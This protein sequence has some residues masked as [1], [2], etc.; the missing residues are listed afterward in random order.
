MSFIFNRLKSGVDNTREAF[1]NELQEQVGDVFSGDNIHVDGFFSE[2]LDQV[3]DSERFD[4][5]LAERAEY[6]V[7]TY[8]LVFPAKAV[9]TSSG[10]LGF[11]KSKL[12]KD[13]GV[14][15]DELTIRREKILK[16]LRDASFHVRLFYS[17]D[18]SKIFAK[19]GATE[20]RF[21]AVAEAHDYLLRL[22]SVSVKKVLEAGD[23]LPNGE[24]RLPV[25]LDYPYKDKELAD[26]LL[27]NFKAF[28]A[29]GE[30]SVNMSTVAKKVHEQS[31]MKP[32]TYLHVKYSSKAEARIINDHGV[33]I[34]K[35]YG[36]SIL[37]TY[38]RIKLT[39]ISIET[40]KVAI[41][42]IKG[43]GLNLDKEQFAGTIS[44]AY[45]V[46][47]SETVAEN[48]ELTVDQLYDKWRATSHKP[49]TQPIDDIREYAGE[50][51]ALYFAFLGFYTLWLIPAALV[52]FVVF[53][54]QLYELNQATGSYNFVTGNTAIRILTN[55][56]DGDEFLVPL[57]PTEVPELPYYAIFIAFWGSFL[58]EFWKRAQNTLSLKWGTS[59]YERM[60]VVRPEF[61]PTFVLP[62]VVTGLP[63]LYRS[64][65]FFGLK[66]AASFGTVLFFVA[67]VIGAIFGTLVF[68]EVV[69]E[70]GLP[71]AIAPQIAL[72]VNAVLIILLGIVFKKVAAFLTDWENHRTDIEYEDSL[73]AKTFLFSFFNS[74]STLMYYAFIKSGTILFPGGR[75]QYCMA[76][77]QELG[78][79]GNFSV[80]ELLDVDSCYGAVG[81]SLFILFGVQIVIS[82]SV[83]VGLP[84]LKS[85]FKIYQTKA[86]DAAKNAQK[87]LEEVGDSLMGPGEEKEAEPLDEEMLRRKLQSPAEQQLFLAPYETP[88]DDYLEIAL[89]FGYVTLFVSAFPLAP[90]F[91]LLAC[92]VEFKV[93]S[94]KICFLS[95]KPD[96]ASAQDIGTWLYIFTILSFISV[97]VNS[98]ILFFT[99]KE[100]ILTTA[101]TDSNI[102]VWGF[103][104]FV[105]GIYS[106]KLI[107]DY[108]ITDIPAAVSIQLR[109]QDHIERKIFDLEPD[110]E[111]SLDLTGK[112][113]KKDIEESAHMDD[114]EY[115]QN[116]TEVDGY[117][118]LIDYMIDHT[119]DAL[120]LQG[121]HGEKLI[122]LSR[123]IFEDAD[124]NKDGE[125]SLKELRTM[126]KS[127]KYGAPLAAMSKFEIKLLMAA[128]DLN[129]DGSISPEEFD[130]FMMGES[131][132]GKGMEL[133][134]EEEEVVVEKEE[135]QEDGDDEGG[136]EEG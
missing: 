84:F 6:V 134:E 42:G 126:L 70:L 25:Y 99:V 85:Q 54:H 56:I 116:A 32:F 110:D 50:K 117:D 28:T 88:F 128:M 118:A 78:D 76:E 38:D 49:W 83:E 105:A 71:E 129:G 135:E 119:R 40:P 55:P 103:V 31:R 68:K 57:R 41:K 100:P 104:L 80:E 24:R 16:A 106:F 11:V 133:E 94:S 102:R 120:K 43:A 2:E 18:R 111:D 131:K 17:N 13:Y 112:K 36:K 130:I 96:L 121:F 81:Y 46:S 74:Y 75:V 114:D 8:V 30:T 72:V 67:S 45:P 113:S 52:G 27:P 39:Q 127:A 93:D 51:I 15:E 58:L 7:W 37:R 91:A 90:V 59:N 53:S 98:G 22:S 5:T 47:F 61:E 109:R 95:R 97:I 86:N 73:I 33:Q 123:R 101:P 65:L 3:M 115:L 20:E 35:K 21:L 63:E 87:R 132:T 60:A 64:P 66:L 79:A 89:Q 1:E 10:C 9:P 48:A 29:I 124:L 82:N 23:E 62:D 4:D 107:V 77:V 108:F 14:T 44:A 12:I 92:Y 19:V 125:V 34:Y 122:E 69:T 26:A 136:E